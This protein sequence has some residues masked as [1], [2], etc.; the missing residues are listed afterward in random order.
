[1]Q[2]SCSIYFLI[3]SGKIPAFFKSSPNKTPQ[4]PQPNSSS[5]QN[6]TKKNKPVTI[7]DPWKIS[8]LSYRFK[9]SAAMK[10][11][12]LFIS[13]LFQTASTTTDCPSQL[14]QTQGTVWCPHAVDQQNPI[15]LQFLKS[16]SLSFFHRLVSTLCPSDATNAFS[17]KTHWYLC[18]SIF[19]KFLGTPRGALSKKWLFYQS[20]GCQT[21]HD[22]LIPPQVDKIELNCIIVYFSAKDGLS[23][24]CS[25]VH[26]F[27]R[28]QGSLFLQ[29]CHHQL[30][31]FFILFFLFFLSMIALG[32]LIV[33][34]NMVFLPACPQGKEKSRM[35][36]GITIK[37]DTRTEHDLHWALRYCDFPSQRERTKWKGKYKQC[38]ICLITTQE[39]NGF[40][41]I[42]LKRTKLLLSKDRT[43]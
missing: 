28:E 12:Y 15:V 37:P 9:S 16:L 23:N 21:V 1:M 10:S 35:K 40:L 17:S 2:E 20:L 19:Q 32:E 4:K 5:K 34:L 31:V 24:S 14:D 26:P 29:Y 11:I 39:K 42:S 38:G 13:L 33:I 43:N 22:F 8:P 3:L 36:H 41:Q 25:F 6:K 30:P 7:C 27:F 18:I